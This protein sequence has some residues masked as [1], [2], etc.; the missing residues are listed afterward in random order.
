MELSDTWTCGKCG[1]TNTGDVFYGDCVH[2]GDS[3]KEENVARG[4]EQVEDDVCY[5][6]QSDS[7]FYPSETRPVVRAA[8]EK[9]LKRAGRLPTAAEVDLLVTGGDEGEPPRELQEK[10]EHLNAAIV[11]LFS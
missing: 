5:C 7:G 8:L 1:G 11:E 3:W 9:D 6:L 10:F 4:F 2:C